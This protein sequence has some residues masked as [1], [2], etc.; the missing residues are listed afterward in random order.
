MHI[1]YLVHSF[2]WDKQ[3]VGGAGQYVANIA[4]IM[5][6]NGH[7]VDIVVEASFE[8]IKEVDGINVH[9][10]NQL[11]DY[12]KG[13]PLSTWTKVEKNLKR[14]YW[15]NQKVKEIHKK[16]KV[17]I[18]QSTNIFSLALLRMKQIPYVVRVSEYPALWRYSSM[19]EFEFDSAM[20]SRRMDEEISLWACKRADMVIAPSYFLK[21]IY[22]QRVEKTV[23]VIESP[24]DVSAVEDLT[25][26]DNKLE[27]DKYVITYGRLSYRKEIHVIA[28]IVDEFLERHPSMKYVIV[29]ENISI[30]CGNK[31]VRVWDYLNEHV[32]KNRERL[33][34][35]KNIVDKKKL[36][37][38]IKNAYA[39]VLP[40][41]I[42]NLPNAV[43][44]AMALKKIV[45]SS[46]SEQGTSIEQLIDDG[47][48]GFLAQIDDAEGLLNKIDIVMKLSEAERNIIEQ[49]AQERVA[50]LAPDKVYEK[51]MKVYEDVI[52]GS[53]K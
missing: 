20:K 30:T 31:N 51:M 7:D 29:G 47:K 26:D 40:T 19:Q 28:D 4:R 22:E 16:N 37:C 27:K 14:S 46:T 42:D 23:K 39:C 8:G 49:K 18:V 9:A 44:E 11:G 2:S 53:K 12:I 45:I 15:Y 24:V 3:Y 43:L 35:I 17:D 6:N 5:K 21:T 32:I 52:E 41:R 10:V 33:V 34:L 38:I 13:K 25:L 36:F 48:N 50:D 1:V